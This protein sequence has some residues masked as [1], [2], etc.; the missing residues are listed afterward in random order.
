M[1]RLVTAKP[2]SPVQIGDADSRA[3]DDGER[4]TGEGAVGSSSTAALRFLAVLRFFAALRVLRSQSGFTSGY[5]VLVELPFGSNAKFVAFVLTQLR[6][7]R[8]E[9]PEGRVKLWAVDA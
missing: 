1:A 4:V 7:V 8:R 9:L 2:R 5:R 6:V 3:V